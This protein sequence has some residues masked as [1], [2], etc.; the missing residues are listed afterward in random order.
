MSHHPAD[1][2]TPIKVNDRRRVNAEGEPVEVEA[3]QPVATPKHDDVVSPARAEIDHEVSELRSQLD[4]AHKRINDLAHALQAGERD[5]EEF[6]QRQNRERERMIDVE[7]GN[8]ARTILEVV[9]Q[10][11]LCLTAADDS[12]LA[13]GVKLIRESVLK[14]AEA[15]GIE[16]VELLGRP[17]DPNF[18]EATDM[19]ITASES[20]DGKVTAVIRSAYQLKGRVIR[21]GAVK[22]ARYVKPAE[23]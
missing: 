10:L 19:E 11:D 22:V 9:D 12:P 4:A 16:R 2:G 20:D 1:E 21:P 15:V 23:A 18:A 5:R 14:Q 6:K 7:K 3:Q 17:Y 13:K 8:V